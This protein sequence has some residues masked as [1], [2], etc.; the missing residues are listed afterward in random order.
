MGFLEF[1]ELLYLYYI[2]ESMGNK[3]AILVIFQP[4]VYCK[5]LSKYILI[6]Q[7]YSFKIKV[8]I[9]SKQQ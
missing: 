7:L 6:R 1:C 4:K 8:S 2:T 3:Q 5:L 9:G